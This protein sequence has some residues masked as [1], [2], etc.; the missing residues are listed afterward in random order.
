MCTHDIFNRGKLAGFTK[1][2]SIPSG[3]RPPH[4]FLMA[5]QSGGL[6]SYGNLSGVGVV[7]NGNLAGGI[8]NSAAIA[9]A[10]SISNADMK[11]LIWASASIAAN[12]SFNFSISGSVNMQSSIAGSGAITNALPF[13]IAEIAA[14]IISGSIM[15]GP[16]LSTALSI[17]ANIN[18][19]SSWD[20]A[21]GSLI[22]ALSSAIVC[23]A[24]VNPNASPALNLNA[25]INAVGTMGPSDIRAIADLA[26]SMLGVASVSNVNSPS[27]GIL[28]ANITPF[29]ELSPQTLSKAVWDQLSVDNNTNG[30]MGYVLNNV[31]AGGISPNDIA[32][33]VWAALKTNSSDP[34]SMGELMQEVYT[35]VQK[36]L[37]KSEFLALK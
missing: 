30:T 13:V 6:A 20:D 14:S 27:P 7:S 35:E 16:E 9:G 1:L 8:N 3:T 29:T 22:G 33:A 24:I 25:A 18:G 37:K 11:L 17:F 12:S 2:V 36:R 23:T 26:I 19:T 4:C 31:S 21:N 34:D 5:Q 32:D 10:G 15:S 28:N